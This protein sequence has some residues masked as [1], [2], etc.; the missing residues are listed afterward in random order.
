MKHELQSQLSIYYTLFFCKHVNFRSI[1]SFF[2]YKYIRK[3]VYIL[4]CYLI[5]NLDGF[6]VFKNGG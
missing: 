2:S 1:Q 6:M 3:P 5:L 4:R